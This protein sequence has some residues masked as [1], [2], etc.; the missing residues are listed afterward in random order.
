M[1]E[2]AEAISRI[3]KVGIGMNYIGAISVSFFSGLSRDSFHDSFS[4]L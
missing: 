3:A 2:R 4:W 1:E